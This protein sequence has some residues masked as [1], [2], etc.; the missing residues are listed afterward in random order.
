MGSGWKFDPAGPPAS[1]LKGPIPL[2]ARGMRLP[3]SPG[4]YLVTCGDCLAHV[5]TSG[6]LADR[7][8][9]L[10]R[11]GAHHG[12]AE[13]LCAAFCSREQP[14]VWWEVCPSVEVARRRETAFKRHYGEPPV[15]RA[16]YGGCKDGAR[17]RQALVE[18][19]GPGTWEAGY[20]EALFHTGM[21]LNLLFQPRLREI[22]GR[23]G[24]PPGPWA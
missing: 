18:A 11:L 4:L 8:R 22:W 19:A 20:I 13:V 3:N 15:P 12:S 23:V 7:V 21:R 17:L 14:L 5:G 9:Q 24:V 10:A 1:S 16:S 6:K 2:A